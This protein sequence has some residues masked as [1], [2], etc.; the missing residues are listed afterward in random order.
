MQIKEPPSYWKMPFGTIQL[1]LLN[2]WHKPVLTLANLTKREI[3][4]CHANTKLNFCSSSSQYKV[5]QPLQNRGARFTFDSCWIRL[6]LQRAYTILHIRLWYQVCLNKNS[7]WKKKKWLTKW[8]VKITIAVTF[9][10]RI[11]PFPS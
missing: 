7:V 5:G 1:L 3:P 10:A 8:H 9:I 4:L 6:R 11:I 2:Y